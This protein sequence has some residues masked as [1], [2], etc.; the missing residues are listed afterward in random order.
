METVRGLLSKRDVGTVL[1]T[2]F[3]CEM[4]IKNCGLAFAQVMAANS[5]LFSQLRATVGVR[6]TACM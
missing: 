6:A 4:L 3:L 5:G 1:S 2:L